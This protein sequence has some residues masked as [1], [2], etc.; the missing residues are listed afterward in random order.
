MQEPNRISSVSAPTEIPNYAPVDPLDGRKLRAWRSTYKDP[1]AQKGIR[2]EAI[3]LA[4]LLFVVPIA[5]VFLWLEYPK[6]ML[7]LSDQKYG[8]LLKYGLAWLSG[9]L[10]GTLF[11]VKWLYHSVARQVWHLD[12]RLW[13]LFTPHISGGLAFAIVAL[14]SSGFI[15][16]FD[17]QALESLSLVTGV[18][19]LVG[20]FSDSAIAKLAE[21]AETIFGASRAKE[22]HKDETGA[23]SSD[24]AV[25]AKDRVAKSSPDKAVN[26]MP[27]NLEVLSNEEVSPGSN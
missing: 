2:V 7:G 5:I 11:D 21:I 18:A 6:Q 25:G 12:R 19:F 17:P 8:P 26:I 9:V 16:I 14:I 1:E 13:R 4:V 23:D 24:S 27:E 22:K 20:Y 3:Y 15:R 10:G